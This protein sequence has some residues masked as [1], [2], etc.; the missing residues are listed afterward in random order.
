MDGV[1]TGKSS[2]EAMTLGER[3]GVARGSVSL[4]SWIATSSSEMTLAE[5][6]VGVG[7]GGGKSMSRGGLTV[8]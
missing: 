3:S 1:L 5:V 8:M 6:G 7:S 2:S 4:M